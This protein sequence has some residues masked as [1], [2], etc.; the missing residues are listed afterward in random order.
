M[1]FGGAMAAASSLMVDGPVGV[2]PYIA[3]ASAAVMAEGLMRSAID[4]HAIDIDN[5]GPEAAL[6]AISQQFLSR[7]M[8]TY[9]SDKDVLAA[10]G[11][12]NRSGPRICMGISA[13]DDH[14]VSLTEGYALDQSMRTLFTEGLHYKSAP[15]VSEKA[16]NII[17]DKKEILEPKPDYAG[18]IRAKTVSIESLVQHKVIGGGHATAMAAAPFVLVPEIDRMVRI[19]CTASANWNPTNDD[20]TSK[21]SALADYH[22]DI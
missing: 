13:K 3:S 5:N 14:F 4:T 10:A 20:P 7:S 18:V 1:S 22:Y 12:R 21:L 19:I 2:V 8:L 11:M 6:T 17:D 16:S 9:L 15:D